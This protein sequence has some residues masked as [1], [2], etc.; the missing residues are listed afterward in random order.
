MSSQ[1]QQTDPGYEVADVRPNAIWVAAAGLVVCV[2]V[3]FLCITWMFHYLVRRDLAAQ[4]GSAMDRITEAVAATRPQYPA[5]R[6]QVAPHVDL[7]ALRSREEAELNGYG[8][9]DRKA[10][11]VRIPIDRAMDLIVQRGLPVRGQPNAP[12]PRFTPLDMQQ[13]RPLQIPPSETPK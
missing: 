11:A 13:A 2:V 12:K 9:V 7:A 3:V 10:G 8:W 4:K 5:P 1:N 6:L